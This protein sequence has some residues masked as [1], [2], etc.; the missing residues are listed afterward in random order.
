M[1]PQT[2]LLSVLT[3]AL[4][5]IF[6]GCGNNPNEYIYIIDEYYSYDNKYEYETHDNFLIYEHEEFFL[7]NYIN[8]LEEHT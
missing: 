1:K 3:A 4:I 5:F 2:L 6:T 8:I 7:K